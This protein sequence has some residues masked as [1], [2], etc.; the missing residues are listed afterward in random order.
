MRF[1]DFILGVLIGRSLCGRRGTGKQKPATACQSYGSL[2]G[3]GFL[4]YFAMIILS[5]FGVIAYSIVNVAGYIWVG[6]IVIPLFFII[7][8]GIFKLF[9]RLGKEGI[10]TPAIDET[11]YSSSKQSND[12][13]S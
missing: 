3:L 8:G 10:K 2:I 5:A 6:M 7:L 11:N 4:I 1:G 9:K 13:N 12:D